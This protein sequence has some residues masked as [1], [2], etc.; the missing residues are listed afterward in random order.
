MKRISELKNAALASLKGQWENAV[1][2]FLVYYVIVGGGNILLY[3]SGWFLDGNADGDTLTGQLL[4]DVYSLL[5]VPL[6]WGLNCYYLRIMRRGDKVNVGNIFSG[7]SQFGRIFLTLLL[8]AVYIFLWSLLL[9]VPGIVKSLS[10]AMT[11]FV[12]ADNPELKYNGAIE[13]SMKLM[14]GHKWQF[15][16][17]CLSFIGWILLCILTFGI[18]FLWLGPYYQTTMA[19]FYEDLLAEE[20]AE[21]SPEPVADAL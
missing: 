6:A 9:F 15:F 21:I 13:R 1:L 12:L 2:T 10:Y 5:A 7:Y 18:G 20:A 17:L 4:V 14:R 3:I 8:K 16:V 11:E 19:A